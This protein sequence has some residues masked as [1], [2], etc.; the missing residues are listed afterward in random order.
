MTN[1]SVNLPLTYPIGTAMLGRDKG[2]FGNRVDCAGAHLKNELIFGVRQA[3]VIATAGVGT[4]VLAKKP[5]LITKIVTFAS[6][7]TKNLAN[8]PFVKNT[9]EKV[10]TKLGVAAPN[11]LKAGGIMAL[12]ALPLLAGLAVRRAFK[13]GQ[14]DQKYTD[15]AQTQKIIKA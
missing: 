9:I 3:A 1:L 11:L 4:V 15:R 14:I 2:S 12:V 7:A 6:T 13:R 8:K 5:A 10:A